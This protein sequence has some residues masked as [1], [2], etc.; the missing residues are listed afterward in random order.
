[1]EVKMAN[2]IKSI[3][4]FGGSVHAA[5]NAP[6]FAAAKAFFTE[7][8]GGVLRVGAGVWNTAPIELCSD[9]T[10]QLD[11]GA[12][13]SFIP[14]FELYRPVKTRWEGV[15][16]WAMHPCLFVSNAHDVSITGS[17]VLD[18]NGRLWW[19]AVPVKRQQTGPVDP[20]EKELASLNP[21]YKTHASGG[22]GRISQFLRPS[23]LQF[24]E[25]TDVHVSGITLR[26]SPCWT[27]HPVFCDRLTVEGMHVCNPSDSPN[28]D[29][30]DIDSC[31]NVL[32][33][34][35]RISV[36][37]DGICIKSG[38]G[39]DGIRVNRPSDH[40]TV[41]GCTVEK[42]HGG[43]VIGS[44]TAGGVHN[45]TVK[46]CVFN[47]TD[48]GIRIKTRRG[49]G[50]AI[51]GL[52]FDGITITGCLCPITVNMFYRCG[53]KGTENELFSQQPLPVTDSTPSIRDVRIV[54]VHA[55]GCRASAGFVAG[56][57]E[58]PVTGLSISDST[59]SVAETDAASPA[60]A[61]M[62]AGVPDTD[63]KSFRIINADDPAF[64]GVNVQGVDEPFYY[65]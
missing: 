25:C 13:L 28:T 20:I 11:E 19:D 9:M 29:G 55:E 12:V 36:G 52:T 62:Y 49:R 57:P 30:M 65:G 31:T 27:F 39:P 6:A 48:R 37:D 8:G 45:V 44:E 43:V 4:E 7:S 60:L 18:G 42:G 17:G 14:Q 24:Y 33:K 41:T 16:C 54:N 32:V 46:D 21:D 26:N 59:F 56:L 10:L 15:C 23:L 47:G 2:V 3:E 35:C 22:G 38:S 5:D 63:S 34:D 51:S 1:M 50:G 58:S 64:A 53:S 40:I 61:E